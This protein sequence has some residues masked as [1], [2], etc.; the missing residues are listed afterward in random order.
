MQ[1]NHQ[2]QIIENKI[3]VIRAQFVMLDEDLA[4]WYPLETKG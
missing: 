3:V 2:I 1:N 4:K